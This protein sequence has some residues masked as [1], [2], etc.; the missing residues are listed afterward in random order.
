MHR[1]LFSIGRFELHTYGLMLATAFFVGI[2]LAMRRAKRAGVDPNHIIDLS[3]VIVIASLVGARITY[4]LFHMD[5][6]RGHWLDVVNPFQS[7]GTIGI[8]GLVFLGGGI[9]AAGASVWFLKKRKL[10]VHKIA[11]ILIPSLALGIAITRVGCFFNGCCFGIA[12]SAPWAMVFPPDSA[13]GYIF[14]SRHIHPTQ[15][16]SSLGGF[17]IFLSLLYSERYKTFDGFTTILF[18]ILYSSF[19]FFIEFFRWYKESMK[20]F[21]IGD[22]GVTVSQFFSLLLFIGGLMLLVVVRRYQSDSRLKLKKSR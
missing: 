18:L 1:T 11:D 16:Y 3:V 21:F 15:I 4:V 22:W 13:A 14:P 19:R 8:A 20:L 9:L 12:S 6:F 10:P 2:Y 5:E 7:D 17:I